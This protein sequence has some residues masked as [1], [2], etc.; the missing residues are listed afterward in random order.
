MAEALDD[1]LADDRQHGWDRRQQLPGSIWQWLND[2]V[3]VDNLS[4]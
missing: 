1:H 4:L 3:H 2:F